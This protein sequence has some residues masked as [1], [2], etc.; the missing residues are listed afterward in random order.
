VHFCRQLREILLYCLFIPLF[1]GVAV[2]AAAIP[3]AFLPIDGE[4]AEDGAT[5]EISW[6]K[7]ADWGVDP[8]SIQRRVLGQTY[9]VSWGSI[10]S[11][12]NFARVYVDEN[13]KPGVAYEYR[14]S[15]PSKEKIQTGYWTTGRHLPALEKQGVAIVIVDETLA[16]DLGARLDRFMLDL[17]GDGWKVIR[18]D[19][20]RG[21]DNK[22]NAVANLNAARKLRALIQSS[23]NSDPSAS[24]ALILVGHIPIVKSGRSSPDG[25]KPRPQETDLFYADTDGAWRDNG[26]GVLRH[27]AIPGNHIEM[28][29]G[30]ID[31]SNLDDPPGNE[32]S[33]LKRYFDKNHHWRHGRLGDLRQAYG[34]GK[35]HLS[36]EINALRNI[37]GPNEVL[38][39]GHHDVGTQQPWLFGMDFGSHK[40]DDYTTAIPIKSVFSLNFGSWKL[41]YSRKKNTMTAMLAQPWYGLATG[42]GA[43]PAWQLHHM[44][45]GKSI[46]YSH[47]RTVNNGTASFGGA[48]TLEYTPTGDYTWVNPIWVNLL[49]DPTLHPFPLPS[50]T[51]PQAEMLDGTVKISWTAADTEVKVQYRVYR[52]LDR[53]GPYKPL[54]TAQLHSGHQYVDQNPVV[55][56]WYMVR[57]HALKEVYAGSFHTFSQ[58]AFAVVG[59]TPPRVTDQ[60]ISTPMGQDIKFSL[61]GVDPDSDNELTRSI[62]EGP[63]GGHLVQS[64][65]DWSFSPDAGFSGRV[66]IPF[67]VFDG[68]GSDK[69]IVSI[70]V[71]EPLKPS[72]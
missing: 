7:A 68:V 65:D 19:V 37:V 23:Y 62:I 22:I 15:R 70:D 58:G 43:R 17:I 39:G 10:A 27:N 46:G 34:R 48:Q 9:K 61:S 32:I 54:N 14:I 41:N 44:A 59:N 24:H 36:V 35:G 1:P 3:E 64:N 30:R 71:T 38:E 50:V 26:Q 6:A 63:E 45:L 12:R 52:A 28:Q 55:G 53:F 72:D 51:H 29:V 4:I 21:D 5:I 60:L 57:A 31:F 33:L 49:G 8:V 16:G 40:Y 18:H 56:A 13:V 67:T 47:L 20:P 25:H 42:W 69:G 11:L 2:A 66:K